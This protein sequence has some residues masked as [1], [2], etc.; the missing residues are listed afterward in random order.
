M[1]LLN[2]LHVLAEKWRRL[3]DSDRAVKE[4]SLGMRW[5]ADELTEL[6]GK[7]VVTEAEVMHACRVYNANLGK[8]FK[9]SS[10]ALPYAMGKV[11]ESA[12][13]VTK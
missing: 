4:W 7:A 2:E 5:C 10:L 11:L 8:P 9:A 12:L 6:L 1:T 3:A 13:G